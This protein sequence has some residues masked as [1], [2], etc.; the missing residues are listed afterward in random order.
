M[1]VLHL[2]WDLHIKNLK[3]H[4]H[5]FGVTLNAGI[6][7]Q[8]HFGAKCENATHTPKRGKMESSR[9]PENSEDDLRGQ[10]YSPWCVPYIN[11][12]ILKRRCPKWPCIDH[13]DI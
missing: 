1:Q 3:P 7:S 9:T 13:L 12:K 4:M 6:V 10:I 11:E 8:P 5:T 2:R